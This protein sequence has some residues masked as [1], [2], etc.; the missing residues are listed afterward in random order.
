[1]G[2]LRRVL[3]KSKDTDSDVDDRI[4]LSDT[5]FTFPKRKYGTQQKLLGQGV[6]GF[7]HLYQNE[8]SNT[9]YA[10]KSFE[11]KNLKDIDE[12]KSIN[13]EIDIHNRINN[14][15]HI[16][17]LIDS[18]KIKTNSK[19]FIIMQ[20]LPLNLLDLYLKYGSLMP[21]SYRLCFFKQIVLGIAFMHNQNIAHRDIKLENCCVDNNGNVKLIDFGSSTIGDIGYGMAGSPSYSAPEIHNSLK[22]NSIKSDIW[23]LGIVLINMFYASKQKWNTCRYDDEI[24]LYYQNN[25][26]IDNAV[27]FLNKND[28]NNDKKY[29]SQKTLIDDIILQLLSIDVNTRI[30]IQKLLENKW[31]KETECCY[32]DNDLYKAYHN[33]SQ[34]V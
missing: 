13:K 33:H 22:Y 24:F 4:K 26:S 16:V 17:K 19:F 34:F 8:K 11:K 21:I 7:V 1:M 20:Y 28:T 23:S 29:T 31:F 32:P 12:I 25:S 30:S 27:R 15:P 3:L 10:V 18:F 14:G 5:H 6:S 9:F 2:V